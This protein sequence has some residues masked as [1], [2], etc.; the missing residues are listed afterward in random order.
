MTSSEPW[1]EDLSEDWGGDDNN[2]ES[3]DDD[4]DT[5]PS[6]AVAATAAAA[7]SPGWPAEPATIGLELEA[8]RTT[9][10]RYG[11]HLEQDRLLVP[12]H[13]PQP[14]QPQPQRQR[15]CSNLHWAQHQD[16]DEPAVATPTLPPPPIEWTRRQRREQRQRRRQRSRSSRQPLLSQLSEDDE[17]MPATVTT[18]QRQRQRQFTITTT[19]NEC[20]QYPDKSTID[21][22]QPRNDTGIHKDQSNERHDQQ[23]LSTNDD[24]DLDEMRHEE[25]EEIEED[26]A[27]GRSGTEEANGAGLETSQEAD[28]EDDSVVVMRASRDDD[29]DN[30]GTTQVKL[31]RTSMNHDDDAMPEWKKRLLNGQKINDLFIQKN[32]IESL[33]D[34]P[35]P[36]SPEPHDSAL[37]LQHRAGTVAPALTDL[38]FKSDEHQQHQQTRAGVGPGHRIANSASG[39]AAAYVQED[40]ASATRSHC[41][42]AQEGSITAARLASELHAATG[43][44]SDASTYSSYDSRRFTASGLEEMRN[45]AFTPIQIRVEGSSMVSAD[46]EPTRQVLTSGSRYTSVSP[47]SIDVQAS[48]TPA[49]HS[50]TNHLIQNALSTGSHRDA[51]VNTSRASSSASAEP[52]SRS[53]ARPL[54]SGSPRLQSSASPSPIVSNPRTR[55]SPEQPSPQRRDEHTAAYPSASAQRRSEEIIRPRAIPSQEVP[56]PHSTPLKLFGNHD[57]ITNNNLLRRLSQ[58]GMEDT[59]ASSRRPSVARRTEGDHH[60]R[61]Q[62]PPHSAM[63]AR[64]KPHMRGQSAPDYPP[65]ILASGLRPSSRQDERFEK[66]SSRRRA[67]SKTA[68]PAL[69]P[70][71]PS[72]QAPMVEDLRPHARSRTAMSDRADQYRKAQASAAQ[73]TGRDKKAIIVDSPDCMSSA[74]SPES[75]PPRMHRRQR[76]TPQLSPL[77]TSMSMPQQQPPASFQLPAVL[78]SSIAVRPVRHD[79][80][81]SS[82]GIPESPTDSRRAKSRFA[83]D[84]SSNVHEV[85]AMGSA[86][87]M[88]MRADAVRPE[89][90]QDSDETL[91]QRFQ[92]HFADELDTFDESRRGSMTTGDFLQEAT[93]VMDFIRANHRTQGTPGLD[94]VQESGQDDDEESLEMPARSPEPQA[95][96]EEAGLGDNYPLPMEVSQSPEQAQSSRHILR[97][98]EVDKLVVATM[99]DQNSSQICDLTRFADDSDVEQLDL[100]PSV[101]SLHLS[102]HRHQQDERHA[103]R[104]A[105]KRLSETRVAQVKREASGDSG[106][107]SCTDDRVR[108]KDRS[109]D[110]APPRSQ[111]SVDS[112]VSGRSQAST[113]G[114]G[115][116]NHKGAQLKE[117]AEPPVLERVNSTSSD[118]SQRQRA[119]VEPRPVGQQQAQRSGQVSPLSFLDTRLNAGARRGIVATSNRAQHHHGSEQ[120]ARCLSGSTGCSE[121]SDDDP[122]RDISDLSVDEALESR[123][124]RSVRCVRPGNYRPEKIHSRSYDCQAGAAGSTAAA[125]LSDETERAELAQPEHA[126]DAAWPELIARDSGKGLGICFKAESVPL[127]QPPV[128]HALP[129]PRNSS[130]GS[131]LTGTTRRSYARTASSYTSGPV[132][133]RNTTNNSVASSQGSD[134]KSGRD[135]QATT[136]ID[137]THEGDCDGGRGGMADTA[138]LPAAPP[139][140][141]YPDKQARVV[142]ITDSA[143]SRAQALLSHK[144]RD[145]AAYPGLVRLA[146]A[147]EMTQK[148]DY[149]ISGGENSPIK[150]NSVPIQ[151]MAVERDHNKENNRPSRLATARP[152]HHHVDKCHLQTHAQHTHP[153]SFK[154]RDFEGRPISRIDEERSA[155]ESMLLHGNELS[156]IPMAQCGGDVSLHPRSSV[157]PSPEKSYSF[158]LT[159]L[160]DFTLHP[161]DEEE[162]EL[163]TLRREFSFIGRRAHPT[164]LCQARGKYSQASEQLVRCLTDVEENPIEWD[165]IRQLS[166]S[167]KQILATQHLDRLCPRLEELDLS[168]NQMTQA[169]GI[170]PSVRMLGL[171]HNFLSDLTSWGHLKNLQYLDV[172]N[173]ELES[174]DAFSGMVHLRSLK[175]NNNRITRLGNIIRLDGLLSLHL[176]GNDLLEVDFNGCTCASLRTRMTALDL[177]ENQIQRVRYIERLTS[178]EKLDISLQFLDVSCCGLEALP[179]TLGRDFPSLRALNLNFNALNDLSGLTGITRLIRLLAAGNRIAGLRTICQVLEDVGGRYGSLRCVDLRDNPMTQGFYPAA[180]MAV[181]DPRSMTLKRKPSAFEPTGNAGDELRVKDPYALPPLDGAADERYVQRLDDGTRTRRRVAHCLIMVSAGSRLKLLDGLDVSGLDPRRLLDDAK[182]NGGDE[183]DVWKRLVEL[184]VVKKRRSG[185]S[186]RE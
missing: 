156:V 26:E 118:Y 163:G 77:R 121:A 49:S 13:Q 123:L 144:E 166:L 184:G 177:R 8:L 128:K 139:R 180:V 185:D 9:S 109:G 148:Q 27:A 70:P 152:T 54:V 111:K 186:A 105:R 175:A 97:M 78:P 179:P 52:N 69:T 32:S 155:E 125:G 137:L 94:S 162:N 2:G 65:R 57:T 60:D 146:A 159:T 147:T 79:R 46:D 38:S 21:H 143:R 171:R 15:Q 132:G 75:T 36:A 16:R 28:G 20:N 107:G 135:S 160:P 142:T 12:K 66:A 183:G 99:A 40:G 53:R 71:P 63:P 73:T 51:T 84:K 173:N 25:N 182:G 131:D 19:T 141:A 126:R 35:P 34:A 43:G 59:A 161:V 174:L 67:R 103:K 81:K 29:D 106:F 164:S 18:P 145:G 61:S 122:F 140:S 170:P 31:R 169:L 95:R 120:D 181:A 165:R 3:N 37:H 93:K 44:G 1:L 154:R 39:R 112:D 45:E 134:S 88:M 55:A 116:G 17:E 87:G 33:F 76:S 14:Q 80:T 178:L 124:L 86:D 30:S 150:S 98:S 11:Q 104:E 136:A 133:S 102:S 64:S 149:M 68:G 117:T 168:H 115:V 129:E 4:E 23:R 42:D 72:P 138:G 89:A 10:R 96:P 110:S 22:R 127:S 172:S 153:P 62:A 157:G 24:Y 151:S 48:R 58:L 56:R 47:L 92:R 90:N 108:P 114:T 41:S 119:R 167:G 50:D 5:A 6:S 176:R 85:N 74:S 158:H 101:S 7:S 113:I 91:E 82:D 130:W 100:S 83:A